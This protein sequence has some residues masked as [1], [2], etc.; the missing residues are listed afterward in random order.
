MRTKSHREV[1]ANLAGEMPRTAEHTKQV[2][3]SCVNRITFIITRGAGSSSQSAPDLTVG[4][5]PFAA[6]YCISLSLSC[7]LLTSS[8]RIRSALFG[9]ASSHTGM[10]SLCMEIKADR[11]PA[12]MVCRSGIMRF[13]SSRAR[14]QRRPPEVAPVSL[15]KVMPGPLTKVMVHAA[16]LSGEWFTNADMPLYRGVSRWVRGSL[17]RLFMNSPHWA[18]YFSSASQPGSA[19][20]PSGARKMMR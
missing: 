6:K 2:K 13:G 17:P 20:A 9:S 4:N 19:M 8:S 15:S 5:L 14:L 16:T 3:P 10:S 1:M 11:F 7:W 18:T 12:K